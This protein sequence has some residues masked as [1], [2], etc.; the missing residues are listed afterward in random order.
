MPTAPHGSLRVVLD[1]NVLISAFHFPA[2]TLSGLW[3]PLAEGRFRLI[4]SPAIVIELTEKLRGKFGW[5]EHELRRMLRT[6]VRKAEIVRPSAVVEAVPGDADDNEIVACAVDGKADVIVSGDRHLLKLREY[7]GIP[8]VR[9]MDFLRMV[10]G[11][12]SPL[13]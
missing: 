6:L 11:G 2:G 13:P 8:I 1:T 10:G 7:Q 12:R 4:L 5:E 9:P 3:Q